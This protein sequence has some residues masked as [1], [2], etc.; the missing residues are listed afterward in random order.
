MNRLAY[1]QG[2]EL[3]PL[4][5]TAVC[6]TPGWLRSEMMLEAFETTEATRRDAIG[7]TA[8]PG[9]V[10]RTLTEA[11]LIAADSSPAPRAASAIDWSNGFKSFGSMS[12]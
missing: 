2:H 9:F 5:G 12:T 8:P 6:V 3:A 4:G 10:A 1:S 7:V 11:I